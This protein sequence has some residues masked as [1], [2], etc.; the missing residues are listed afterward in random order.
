MG[1]AWK[2][3]VC[4]PHLYKPPGMTTYMCL[5]VWGWQCVLP[6]VACNTFCHIYKPIFISYLETYLQALPSATSFLVL[7]MSSILITSGFSWK[8]AYTLWNFY[9]TYTCSVK[10]PCSNISHEE[11]NDDE[12]DDNDDG[13]YICPR[14]TG[15][16]GRGSFPEPRIVSRNAMKRVAQRKSLFI[17]VE[18]VKSK[19]R[20]DSNVQV[21]DDFV[22]EE[23]LH[24]SS[25]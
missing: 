9:V 22:E 8:D 6:L 3:Y 18:M 24:L 12:D 10:H 15:R 1:L 7:L 4:V 5:E 20:W 25:H 19:R 14:T 21:R 23:A 17:W 16:W 13:D 11:E 2:S